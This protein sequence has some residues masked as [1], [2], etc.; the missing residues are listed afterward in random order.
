[1]IYTC[2]CCGNRINE[3]TGNSQG[4]TF[5]KLA[6]NDPIIGKFLLYNHLPFCSQH[7][8]DRWKNSSTVID[9]PP[10]TDLWIEKC[11]K[12]RKFKK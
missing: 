11:L 6:D 12:E 2:W 3:R 5:K 1:M 4:V 8:I 10:I 9:R 7:C